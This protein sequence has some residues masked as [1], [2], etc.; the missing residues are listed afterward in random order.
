MALPPVFIEFLGSYT[1]LA[2]TVK[3]VKTELAGVEAESGGS[4]ARLGAVSKAALLGIGVAAVGAAYESVKLAASFQSTMLQISTQAGVP[5]AQLQS[6]GNGVLALAGQVG[7]SPDS[8][9]EALYHIESSFESVGITGPKALDLLKISA[10]GAAVGHADLVDV[11]NALDA[12]VASGIPGVQNFG[13]AMGALNAIVG[14]GDMQMQDLAD[15]LGTGMLATVKTYGLSLNDVGAALATFGDNN[16]RGAAAATALRMSVQAMAKPVAGGAAELKKLGMSSTQM[17]TDMQKGGMLKALNDLQAHL[18]AAG[19]TGNQTGDVITT[20][21]GKKAG[22]GM[23]ILMDQLDRVRSKYPRLIE[24][25]NGF[26]AAVAANQQT[27]SQKMADAKAALEAL[28]TKL[29]TAL[30]PGLTKMM[31]GLSS[32]V[33]FLTTHTGLITA[34]AAGLGAM[35][36][37]F[38]QASIASWSFTDSLLA[39]PVVWIAVGIG[40][41]VAAIVL[42]IT[43]FGQIASWIRGNMPGLASF[44]TN[45]WHGAMKLFSAVW[46][47]AMKAVHAIAVWFDA[48]VLKWIQ[49]RGNDF[50]KWWS[51]Y[52]SEVMTVWHYI[53]DFVKTEA[54]VAWDFLKVGLDIL[55]GVFH[56]AWD[57]IAGVVKV[58]WSVISTVVTFGI[59]LVM[60]VIGLVLDVITGKWGKVRGDLVHLVGQAFADI[61]HFL[62]WRG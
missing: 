16:M 4:M 60:N 18:K 47:D 39:D 2:A 26:G 49:A 1:G 7:F 8:L 12:A 52:G 3:G 25:A 37:G 44:F 40:V 61:W 9:A 38:A 5:K 23:N 31:G 62:D 55:G 56:A 51:K 13:Q 27:F 6:L 15:A 57:L 45:L 50:S 11:T 29:G 14:S 33:G 59:H 19:V 32:V 28:G 17:A 10:E 36:I 24:G 42:L 54:A 30:L 53:W 58:V 20:I 46:N 34:F 41:A 48:N 22:T 35:A 43:H 21:F